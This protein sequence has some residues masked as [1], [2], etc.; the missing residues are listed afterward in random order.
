MKF[1]VGYPRAASSGFQIHC[2]MI[3][4]IPAQE[5]CK[6]MA[7]GILNTQYNQIISK[8]LYEEKE[9]QKLTSQGSACCKSPNLSLLVRRETRPQQPDTNTHTAAYRRLLAKEPLLTNRHHR[10]WMLP[11]HASLG[12]RTC[13]QNR[14]ILLQRRSLPP[15]VERSV[16]EPGWTGSPSQSLWLGNRM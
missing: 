7:K 13:L 5:L 14:T 4:P 10:Q 6:A 11:R 9:N 12:R 16:A 8:S 3:W 1:P 2:A 15:T